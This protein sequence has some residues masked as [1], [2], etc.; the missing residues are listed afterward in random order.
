MRSSK[1]LR[2]FS[3]SVRP[4]FL[5]RM[6]KFMELSTAHFTK[7]DA[8]LLIRGEA[9]VRLDRDEGCFLHVPNEEHGELAER[10]E[11][12]RK[13]GYSSEI[14]N[15]VYMA[16]TYGCDWILFDGDIDPTPGLPTFEW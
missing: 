7:N 13:A 9:V 14:F 12:M 1:S 3:K 15:L 10:L 16:R 2:E 4:R 11:A 5:P 8:K 6:S